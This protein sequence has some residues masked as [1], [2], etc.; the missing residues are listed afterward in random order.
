MTEYKTLEQQIQE[1]WKSRGLNV[2][3]ETFEAVGENRFKW[4]I[5]AE[6]IGQREVLSTEERALIHTALCFYAD[7]QIKN[8]NEESKDVVRRLIPR[9]RRTP[10]EALREAN[11]RK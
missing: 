7:K 8:L 6:G 4:T 5:I 11:K 9:F 3:E 1:L 2:L 10:L